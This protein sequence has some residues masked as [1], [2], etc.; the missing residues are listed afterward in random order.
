[1]KKRNRAGGSQIYTPMSISRRASQKKKEVHLANP[2]SFW[3]G[4]QIDTLCDLFDDYIDS[5]DMPEPEE[6][7]T[8][9]GTKQQFCPPMPSIYGFITQYTKNTSKYIYELAKKP[10]NRRLADCI[11]RVNDL[12]AHFAIELGA[13]NIANPTIAK[14]I[15]VNCTRWTGDKQNIQQ[16]TRQKLDVN[17]KNLG[18]DEIIEKIT[19]G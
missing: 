8:D 16:E 9:H 5:F 4:K 10:E 19:Q 6:H 11:T 7:L 15:I 1:M 12:H 14:T 3:D 17:V 2:H 18:N 13:R